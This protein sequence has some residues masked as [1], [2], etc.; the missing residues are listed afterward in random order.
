VTNNRKSSIAVVGMAFRLPGDISTCDEL[1]HALQQGENL[2]STIDSKRFS[3]QNYTH[4]RQ[5]EAGKSYTFNAGVLSRIDEFDAGFFGITPREARQMDPQQRLL[6]ETAWEALENGN[7]NVESLAGSNCAV[8]VGIGSNEHFFR[9]ANDTSSADSYTMLGNCSSIAANRISYIFDFHGPSMSIDTACSSSLVALHQACSSIWNGE[10]PMAIA[11]GVN[12]LLSPTSFVGFSKASMLSP[13]GQCKSFAANGNGYVR[14]E[15]CV[16][17]FL[18]PLAAA[19][20]DGDPIHAVI[21]NTGINSDG[22]TNGIAL[23]NIHSQTALI[24][25]VHEQVGLTINDVD[26]IEAHGTGTVVGDQIEAMALSA[27]LA[28]KRDKDNPLLIGSIKSNLGHLE[29]ASGLAGVLKTILCLQHQTIPPTLHAHNPNPDIAFAELNIRV[30]DK[31][32]ILPK[33]KK[34]AVIGVNSFGF[35]G[36]N[37]HVKAPPKLAA[38]PPLLLTMRDEKALPMLAKQYLQLLRRCPSDYY[39]IAYAL[40]HCRT[41]HQH[42]AAIYGSDLASLCDTLEQLTHNTHAPHAIMESRLGK[43]LSPSFTQAMARNGKAW[44]PLY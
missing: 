23:P 12:L 10:A 14:S 36:T 33:R 9:F 21:M 25:R 29:V 27:A 1:W 11:G 24:T 34:P 20:R 15:G 38:L 18:K 6:L 44:L 40:S 22:R 31:P 8:Y 42:G 41:L 39:D 16:V 28:K 2:I 19:E 35:G 43:N 7:Q 37:A 17:L 5:S 26:Y 30:V 4:P 32:T 3:F 13:E